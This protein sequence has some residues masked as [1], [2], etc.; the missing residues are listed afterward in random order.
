MSYGQYL[1]GVL[2]YGTL[3][4]RAIG[5]EEHEPLDLMAYLPSYYRG[6]REMEALQGRQGEE[7]GRLRDSLDD[8]LRQAFVETATWGL[9]HW[10][11]EFGLA[12]DPSRPDEWRREVLRAKIRGS[13]TTTR[14]KVIQAAAAFS[15]GE[16]DVVEYPA[17][18]RFE[19]VFIGVLGIPPNMAGFIDML[20]D[21]KPAHLAYSFQYR[22]TWWETLRELTWAQAGEK[23]WS[24]L[25][26]YEG[27]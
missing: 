12:V 18:S 3:G 16:V 8:G 5:P 4:G 7:I 14:Q 24:E 23:T 19:I 27:V 1:Y 21:I 11:L 22:F 13:G 9:E 15:G 26:V 20:E 10:E 2:D 6:I 25:R 17:D